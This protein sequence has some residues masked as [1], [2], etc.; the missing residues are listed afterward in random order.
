M[1]P[2]KNLEKKLENII[3]GAFSKGFPSHVQPVEIAKKIDFELN[4]NKTISLSR[5]FAPNRFYVNLSP[6]DYNH[7]KDFFGAVKKE[8]EDY[9]YAKAEEDGLFA[10]DVKVELVKDRGLNLGQFTVESSI[11]QD[12]KTEVEKEAKHQETKIISQKDLIQSIESKE[13][14]IEDSKTKKIYNLIKPVTIVGRSK[15]SDI[16]LDDPSVSRKHFELLNDGKQVQ[17]ADLGS[18]NGTLI[19]NANVKMK[20]LRNGDKIEAG[21]STLIFRRKNA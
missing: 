6:K 2:L 19:N 16:C 17:L 3:E 9:V 8:L 15:L 12:I 21:K 18:T 14:I 5:T 1:N 20:T 4:S 7:L 11:A 10:S 13:Y